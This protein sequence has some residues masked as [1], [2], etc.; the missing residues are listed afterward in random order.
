MGRGL[1]DL[2]RWILKAAEERDRLYY[3][4]ICEGYFGWTKIDGRSGP[5]AQK[6]DRAAIGAAEYNRVMATVSRSCRR[7]EARGLVHR[8]EGVYTRWTAIVLN[9]EIGPT[10]PT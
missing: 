5:G 1:S 10:P 6:F 2:Q 4:D 3:S 8:I 9:T 7:L